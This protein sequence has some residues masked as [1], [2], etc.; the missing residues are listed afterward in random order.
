MRGTVPCVTA[1]LELEEWEQG[2]EPRLD[3]LLAHLGLGLRPLLRPSS[4]DCCDDRRHAFTV[5]VLI[6]TLE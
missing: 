5:A 6:T 4:R 3:V 2:A 1:T